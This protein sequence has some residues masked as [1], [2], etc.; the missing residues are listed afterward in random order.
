MQPADELAF[1]QATHWRQARDAVL[2]RMRVSADA[3][4]R[5][6]ALI[7]LIAE[8]S[9]TATA[10]LARD[11]SVGTDPAVYAL[12]LAACDAP[13]PDP[14]PPNCQGLSA[15]RW[16]QL[17]PDNG[18]AWLRRLQDA[19]VAHEA[20]ATEAVLH[21]LATAGRFESA[22]S[23]SL[24]R[25]FDAFGSDDRSLLALWTT[26][27][28]V[29]ARLYSVAPPYQV[30]GQQCSL[31]AVRDANRLQLCDAILE[32][33][34]ERNDTLL[35]RAVG[36]RYAA[37]IGWPSGRIDRLLGETEVYKAHVGD[38]WNAWARDSSRAY[39]CDSLRGEVA[40]LRVQATHG[41]AGAM[42]FWLAGSAPPADA[43]IERGRQVRLRWEAP[44][45][46]PAASTT[47][48]R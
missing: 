38:T 2:E 23:G 39:A 21:R 4:S 46:A 30:I 32:R 41:E 44:G 11:A 35:G 47:P 15:A 9:D 7:A 1:D 12:A 27:T 16:A 22:S 29:L 10:Q 17:D 3:R 19:A 40:R 42:R 26:T 24:T 28:Q 13:R 25:L 18:A 34:V 6:I 37:R 20:D 14:P 48:E 45:K 31:S 43:L 36:I 33:L 8:A 5:A